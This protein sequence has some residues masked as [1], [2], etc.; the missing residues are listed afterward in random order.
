MSRI[1]DLY[2][3]IAR[4]PHR[5][6]GEIFIDEA[7]DEGLPKL[8]IVDLGAFRGEF[9]YYAYSVAKEI[10]AV[11]PDPIPCKIMKERVMTYGLNKFKLFNI[12]ISDKKGVGFIN[13]G[14]GG[15]ASLKYEET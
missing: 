10:Y 1:L 6:D 8:T 14:A 3:E 15:G 13:A 5:F 11:E 4:E 2:A 9:G 12:A 7:Y